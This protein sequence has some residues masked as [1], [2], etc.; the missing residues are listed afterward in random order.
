MVE[1][2]DAKCDELLDLRPQF[3]QSRCELCA[4]AIRGEGAPLKDCVAFIDCTK[5]RM[6]RPD[7]N[8]M[9]QQSCYSGHK[10]FHCLIY[11][12]LTTPDGLI[13]ALYGP[14]DRRM[15]DLTILRKS[16]W[17]AKFQ[18]HLKLGARQ[19]HVFGVSAYSL[20]P[21]MQRP[22]RGNCTDV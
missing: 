15:H 17:D 11:Q 19:Y 12:T 5:I 6:S 16:E 7:G 3:L 18:S 20:R 22:F 2:M 13:F 9:N 21:L 14:T 10:R 8:Y 4:N 1:L